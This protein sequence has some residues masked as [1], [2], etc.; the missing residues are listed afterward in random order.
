MD[1]TLVPEI[2]VAHSFVN[3]P[4][5]ARGSFMVSP[6]GVSAVPSP[7]RQEYTPVSQCSPSGFAP[8]PASALLSAPKTIPNWTRQT[9]AAGKNRL[10]FSNG[11][12]F[13][14]GSGSKRSRRIRVDLSP[15]R[16]QHW[17]VAECRV[18]ISYEPFYRFPWSHSNQ[19]PNYFYHLIMLV[20]ICPN[21]VVRGVCQL[22]KTLSSYC[23]IEYQQTQQKNQIV[24]G[25]KLNL[26]GC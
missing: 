20:A 15:H 3:Q 18:K 5:R 1:V 2:L 23:E 8:S 22:G 13:E 7:K 19:S 9:N 12:L 25:I 10:V 6:R 17:K 16:D 14:N 24:K 26:K 11:L 21:F 4:Q